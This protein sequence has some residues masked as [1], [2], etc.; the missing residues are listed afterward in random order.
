MALH[1]W[2]LFACTVFL[3]C[4]TP[5]PNM[6][7]SL[8]RSVHFGVRRSVAAMGGCL[9]ALFL[10]LVVSAAGVGAV[11]QA[12]P[13]L[14]SV[15]RYAGAAYLIWLGIKAWRSAARSAARE[16]DDAEGD[17]EVVTGPVLSVGALYRGGF[18]IGISNPKLLLFAV[19]FFPQFIDPHAPWMVQ[20]GLLVGTF[21][22]CE[23]FWLLMYGM[24]G[25]RLS[26]WL[27]RPG[28]RRAFDRVT[29]AIFVGFGAVLLRFRA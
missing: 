13:W 3:L 27:D 5:G 10:A 17:V 29:G 23:A 1:T 22:G 11:M 14:F 12:W 21:L 28:M 7:H 15:I 19:A 20:F 9:T 6:L 26:R 25:Q 18:L 8:T 4:A 16:G 24:G 2:W